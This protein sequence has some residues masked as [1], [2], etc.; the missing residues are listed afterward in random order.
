VKA[1]AAWQ[2]AGGKIIADEFLCPA[3]KADVTLASF[4]REKKADLDKA[5]VLALAA[6][7]GPRLDALGLARPL[8]LDQPEILLRTRRAGEANYHF[9]VNDHREFGSYV[10]SHGLVMENGLPASG[11]LTFA[12]DPPA[13]L[14]DL[15]AGRE[16]TLTKQHALPVT[17]GPCDGRLFMSLP[18]PIDGVSLV[19]PETAKGGET[20]TLRISVNDPAGK[21]LPAVIPLLVEIRDSNGRLAE[22]S[23]YHASEEGLLQLSLDLAPNED[24]GVWEITVRELASRAS[25]A[26]AMRVSR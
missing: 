18:R 9:L 21:P 10:G 2:T 4:R 24:P 11:S 5:K 8:R 23:G 3:L 1:L 13:H 26:V 7:L 16:F 22:G 15:V 12:Q 6:D 17:L 20:V 19:A 25:A 14:Y